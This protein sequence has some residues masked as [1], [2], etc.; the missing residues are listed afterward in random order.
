MPTS[1]SQADVHRIISLEEEAAIRSD[2]AATAFYVEPAS[3][4][5]CLLDHVGTQFCP[6]SRKSSFPKYAD[7]MEVSEDE[8]AAGQHGANTPRPPSA[9][10]QLSPDERL[11]RTSPLTQMHTPTQQRR[12]AQHDGYGFPSSHHPRLDRRERN[13][14]KCITSVN[15]IPSMV[16]TALAC[17]H[18]TGRL[19]R[20]SW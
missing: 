2:H 4:C 16:A 7:D 3:T 15:S 14:S 19:L 11:H 1:S 8:A 13:H 5:Q 10:Q 20:R 12:Y 6:G 17:A 18:S 9:Y